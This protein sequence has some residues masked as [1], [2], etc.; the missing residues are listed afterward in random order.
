MAGLTPQIP[1]TRDAING[2]RLIT[3]YKEL[4]KQNF[5][6]LLFTIP[7]ERMMDLGF[8]IGLKRFL[9]EMDNPALY[10]RISGRIKQQVKEYLPYIKV[11]N[12]IFDS[13]A[14]DPNLDPNFLS[15]AIE[16]SIIPLDDVDKI[17]LTLP[18]D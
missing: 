17:E 11:D 1:L 4:V 12:V 2:Y 9:F 3:D 14:T 6:N 10:G 5:K 13:A 15:V 8:G 7:G 16:Y 18:N